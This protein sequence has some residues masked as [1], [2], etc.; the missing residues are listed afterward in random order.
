MDARNASK[1]SVGVWID[2]REAVLV[3]VKDLKEEVKRISS[4]VESQLRR[5]GDAPS[6][7]FDECRV[8]SDDRQQR[9]FSGH[10]D[11]Y[12][13]EVVAAIGDADSIFI[14]G[15]GEAKGQ[16]KKLLEKKNLGARV[17][18]VETEDKMTQPQIVQKV[19]KRFLPPA[20]VSHKA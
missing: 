1:T 5:S 6:A 3:S 2:H 17:V 13:D 9:E 10:L 12:Y 4:Q 8:P 14:F 20:F 16:L 18:G 19:L 15:P 7:P 11:Y